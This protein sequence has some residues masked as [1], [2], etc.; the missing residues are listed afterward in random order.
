LRKKK[1]SGIMR[2]F[3]QKRKK[4]LVSIL[5]KLYC[6]FLWKK[7]ERR[8]AL[9]ARRLVTRRKEFSKS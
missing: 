1:R 2:K 9:E 3:C 4:H 5:R 8:A 6:L 7:R